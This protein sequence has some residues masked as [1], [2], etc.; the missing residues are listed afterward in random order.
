MYNTASGSATV[1]DN[2]YATNTQNIPFS[3]NAGGTRTFTAKV[4]G[5]TTVEPDETMAAQLGSGQAQ[6][7]NVVVDTE[8]S[9]ADLTIT[10]GD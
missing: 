3:G 9:S 4:N 7:R 10:N 5:D 8:Q 6:G 1:P 2:D